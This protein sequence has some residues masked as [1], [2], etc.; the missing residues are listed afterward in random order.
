MCDKK[1]YFE[2]I[3]N[4]LGMVHIEM[5]VLHKAQGLE[6]LDV[7]LIK[8]FSKLRPNSR[9]RKCRHIVL[10]ELWIF[11]V[12]EIVRFIN[13]VN[14]KRNIFNL[15]TKQELNKILTKLTLLRVPLAKFQKAGR[16]KELYLGVADSF[17]DSANGVGWRVYVHGKKKLEKGIL[18]RKDLADELLELLKL[19]NLD[20][21]KK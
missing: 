2:W 4:S 1:R 20:I 10:S 11:G 9:L 18:Y 13:E 16:T 7:E 14:K 3:E 15:N 6:I 12:Y 5:L 8:D 19:I 17:L 21:S